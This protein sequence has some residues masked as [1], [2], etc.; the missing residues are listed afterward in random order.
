MATFLFI[1]GIILNPLKVVIC[2]R[3][4]RTKRFSLIYRS[5]SFYD[6]NHSL[7]LALDDKI[8]ENFFLCRASL[9]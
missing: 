1:I 8:F 7:T 3:N 6:R 4:I 5:I 9:F 2:K